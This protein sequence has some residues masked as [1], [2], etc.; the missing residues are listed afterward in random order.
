M[1][2]KLVEREIPRRGKKKRFRRLQLS[3]L[4]RPKHAQERLLHNV[5]DRQAPAEPL[6]Q[7]GPQH[8]LM[9]LHIGQKPRVTVG[10]QATPVAGLG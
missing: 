2:P 8:R 7:P 1:S 3:P 4:V 9:R 10:P 6:H 5:I